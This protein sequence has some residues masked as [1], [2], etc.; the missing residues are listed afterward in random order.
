M[1]DPFAPLFE[2]LLTEQSLV[3]AIFA[4]LWWLE[5]RDN[6]AAMKQMSEALGKLATAFEIWKGVSG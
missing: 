3:A 6:K 1:L 5:R 4:M 2:K